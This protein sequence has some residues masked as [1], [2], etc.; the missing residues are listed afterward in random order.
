MFAIPWR[1][2]VGVILG[3]VIVKESRRVSEY[4]DSAR[5]RIA[6]AARKAKASWNTAEPPSAKCAS[7]AYTENSAARAQPGTV[8][9]KE[10]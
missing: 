10:G 1:L 2:I 8:G 6:E 4:Y 3:A 7:E 5:K 9:M